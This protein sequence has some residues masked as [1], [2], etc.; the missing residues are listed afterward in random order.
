MP[1]GIFVTG[2]G[3]IS[4]I[5]NN[6]QETLSA[7]QEKRSGIAPLHYL[8]TSH[9]EFPVG[10]VKLTNEEMMQLLDIPETDIH[11]R[12]SLMGMIAVREA[13][14]HCGLDPQSPQN[15]AEMKGLRIAFISGTTVGG[16]DKGELYYLDFLDND[17]Q[18]DYIA[19]QNCGA[20][21]E[22]IADYFGI[23]SLV[24][25]IS[26]ACSSAAN[27]IMLGAQL[28]RD[29]RADVVVAGGSECLTKF[30]LNGFNTLMILDREQC[31]PFDANRA[32]LNLGEG[33][34]YIV[35][36]SEESA[37]K[38][39]IEPLARLSGCANTCDAFHQT[40]SSSDGEGAY[41]AMKNA[42]AS[43][44]L[45]P[46]D[47]DYINAHGTGTGNNDLS[48]GIA[49]E[50]L[51]GTKT[52]PVSSTKSF[53]GHTTSAAGGVEAVISLLALQHNFIPVNLNF[54]E[55][56]LEL[57]F[58]PYCCDTKPN[59][60]QKPVRFK[61]VLS[62]SFGFGGNET[63]LVFSK[64]DFKVFKEFKASAVYILDAKQISI[65]SPLVED[66]MNNPL[67]Y[68]EPY[69]RAIDPDYKL[70]FEPNVARR[71]GKVLKRALLTSRQVMEATNITNP[72][73]IITGT[74]LG[75]IENTESFLLAL[76][77]EGE[78]MLKPTH[79]MQSTHNTIG[80]LIAIDTR[81]R[82][83]NSTYS[84][85]GISFESALL[86]AFMQLKNGQIQTALVG[87]HDEMTPKYFTILKRIGYLGNAENGFSGE[88]AVSMMLGAEQKEGALCRI[89]GVEALY[90]KELKESKDLKFLNFLQDRLTQILKKAQC[91]FDDIDAVMIG[92]S[93]E[94]ANDQVYADICP[95]LFPGKKLLRYKHLFGESYT[96]PGLGVYAA[97]TCLHQQRIPA[98]LFLDSDE[99]EQKRV[100]NIL[101][102]NQIENKN[103]TFVLLSACGE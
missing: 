77:L 94:S 73:A 86:D 78:E 88:T 31:K 69:I 42:L 80:S 15:V 52:P 3:I 45:K 34:A 72:D 99:K 85:K 58:E 61:H 83:Y 41:L 18:N 97:A 36:E 46:E 28:I 32:G 2:A 59:R 60:F 44:G 39:N 8:K 84:H 71:L 23:F 27:A 51:F 56:M 11:I 74:G 4:A 43:A 50:R 7:L 16:M 35:L 37:R 68:N 17:T 96:A 6:K 40:A 19:T 102:Y 48:E 87:A 30:H 66:W 82:G 25:T 24:E 47:I 33:A 26:T 57:N 12:T 63:A 93:G 100:K 75:C 29:G 22:M 54:S 21:T 13:L 1:N 98:H 53:T 10:E 90:C 103:H 81:C 64:V 91:S 101:F 65:Q 62:N 49:I 70:Y 5:G 14:C 92:N 76:L 95:T 79:F 67:P 38:R 89:S 55:K 9:T 20:C